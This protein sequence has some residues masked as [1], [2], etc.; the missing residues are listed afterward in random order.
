MQ[1][2][3]Q[4]GL[5]VVLFVQQIRTGF[6]DSLFIT[7]S[8]LGG[9]L[10]YMAVL[11]FIYWCMDRTV[12]TRLIFLFL[13]SEWVNSE[14]K[15]L[16]DQPRPYHLNNS[17][18]IGDTGGPG[19]PSGHAQGSVLF[20]GYLSIW[21]RRTWFAILTAAIILIMALSRLYLGMHF[22]TDIFGGWAI[23]IMLIVLMVVFQDRISEMISGL[24]MRDQ[25]IL[26]MTVPL[27]LAMIA[28]S[29]WSVSPMGLMAGFGTACAIESKFINFA[30]PSGYLQSLIRYISAILILILLDAGM[31]AIF[32]GEGAPSFLIFVYIETLI[33]GLWIG[34]GAPWMFSKIEKKLL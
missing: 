33:D 1:E 13:M 17:V 23:A 31:R 8:A 9:T 3:L 2:I 20:W 16:F 18:K 24:A 32:P 27:L 19:L 5:D 10:F 12:S 6:L 11:P 30:E 34:A 7:I 4:W 14:V 15:S 21:I 25:I 22:P 26:A 29:K 28:P